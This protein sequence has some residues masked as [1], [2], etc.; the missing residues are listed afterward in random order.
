MT[1]YA[2]TPSTDTEESLDI[3]LPLAEALLIVVGIFSLAP[4]IMVIS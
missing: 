4:L 3:V 1:T 2:N